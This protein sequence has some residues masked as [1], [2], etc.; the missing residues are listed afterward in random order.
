LHEIILLIGYFT[1]LNNEN[2]VIYEFQ[3]YE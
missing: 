2:Q 3:V 1:V